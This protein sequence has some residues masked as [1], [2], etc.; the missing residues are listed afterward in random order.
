[1]SRLPHQLARER[2][3]IG[4]DW[5]APETP[6]PAVEKLKDKVAAEVE[7]DLAY[8]SKPQVMIMVV[9]APDLALRQFLL[10][11]GVLSEG[12]MIALKARDHAPRIPGDIL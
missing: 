3:E 10:A 5:K 6:K 12:D 7:A 11:K 9:P 4:H 2:G 1:M 8:Q